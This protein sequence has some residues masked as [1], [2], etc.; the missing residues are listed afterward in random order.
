MTYAALPGSN[1]RSAPRS[2]PLPSDD[3]AHPP[4]LPRSQWSTPTPADTTPWPPILQDPS[5]RSHPPPTSTRLP[6]AATPRTGSANAP[7]YRPPRREWPD[8]LPPP[9]LAAFGPPPSRPDPPHRG[10]A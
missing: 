7:A 2:L 1:C 8:R 9:P 4:H 10:S 3:P 6:P 5:P